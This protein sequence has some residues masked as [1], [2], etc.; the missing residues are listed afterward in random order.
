VKKSS[1]F[2][3]PLSRSQSSLEDSHKNEGFLKSMWHNLT[4]HPAHQGPETKEAEAAKSTDSPAG[5]DAEK[6]QKKA[7]GDDAKKD[8]GSGSA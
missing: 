7:E 2:N 3:V 6:T 1:R 8:T 5:T 4:N